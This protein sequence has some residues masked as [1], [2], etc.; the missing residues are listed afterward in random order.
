MYEV[1]GMFFFFLENVCYCCD[2]MAV[3]NMVCQ[4]F[5]GEFVYLECGYQY[6][7]CGVK[8][9]DGEIVY[10][11]GVEFGEKVFS[12]VCWCICYFVYC[13]GDFYFIYGIGLV[14][15]YININWGNW[16]LYLIFMFI[17]L[18]GLYEYIVN[19]FKGG[20]DYLN[21]SVWFEFG[22]III[23]VVKIVKGESIIISYDINLFC[24]YFLGFWVQGIKGLWMDVNDFIYFEGISFGYQWELVVS[25]LEKYDY[26]FW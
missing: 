6:D 19:Y 20:L 14:V 15:Q 12:E 11:S 3:L 4:D 26:L 25:Y 18:W 17:K 16:L 10:N 21:V 24:F 1:I 23:I 5:F 22:D 7:L 9:N 13:N 2:V 8:F